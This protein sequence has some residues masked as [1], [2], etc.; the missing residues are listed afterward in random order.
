[1]KCS[2][3]VLA[4]HLLEVR[5]HEARWFG[6]GGVRPTSDGHLLTDERLDLQEEL[7]SSR[8]LMLSLWNFFE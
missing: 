4:V 6:V 8:N 5:V 1:M 2:L 7:S 3:D